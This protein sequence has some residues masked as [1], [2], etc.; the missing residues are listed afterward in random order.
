MENKLDLSQDYYLKLIEKILKNKDEDR[1]LALDRYRKSDEQMETPEQFA[2]M[3]RNSAAFLKLASDSTNDVAEIAKE[4]KTL[5]FKDDSVA[6]GTSG[7]DD[8]SKKAIIDKIL[9]D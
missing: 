5:I 6:G 7:F 4:L 8:N 3:G 9:E 2:L 1:E